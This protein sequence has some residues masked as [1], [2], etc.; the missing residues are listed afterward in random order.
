[1]IAQELVSEV[2][3]S[4]TREVMSEVIR[5][6]SSGYHHPRPDPEPG[7]DIDYGWK[8]KR[9]ST[10]ERLSLDRESFMLDA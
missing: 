4:S 9:S 3:C 6:L 2:G 1:M 10:S 7:F 8:H 5:T